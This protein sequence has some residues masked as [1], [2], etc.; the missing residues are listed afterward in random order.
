VDGEEVSPQR[1]GGVQGGADK[2]TVGT[3]L[4]S[5]STCPLSPVFPHVL[6]LVSS[7]VVRCPRIRTDTEVEYDEF[8]PDRVALELIYFCFLLFRKNFTQRLLF[9]ISPH[10]ST[11]CFR[12]RFQKER[13]Y[14]YAS[15][16]TAHVSLL[17]TGT[18][19]VAPF[20]LSSG[21][22]SA[23]LPPRAALHSAQGAAAGLPVG[24][25]YRLADPVSRD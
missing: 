19:A 3:G 16:A 25:A 10:V 22:A 6:T 12:G 23:A 14:Y 18:Q 8:S 9:R 1:P 5:L 17:A 13:P 4:L 24:A 2:P 21:A 7:L 15:A 20:S 11:D